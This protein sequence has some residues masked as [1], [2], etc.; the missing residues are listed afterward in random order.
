MKKIVAL[1]LCMLITLCGCGETA[2][3]E[4]SDLDI[5]LPTDNAIDDAVQPPL[6]SGDDSSDS[7]E[8]ETI[9]FVTFG[10]YEQDNNESNGK[11]P[12]EWRV[13][14]GQPAS[15][16]SLFLISEKILDIGVFDSEGDANWSTS[17]IR[18]WLNDTFLNAAFSQEE[19]ERIKIHKHNEHNVFRNIYD[20]TDC[21]PST[22]D[23]VGL[24]DIYDLTRGSYG[25]K[26][27]NEE[28]DT[29]Y[30]AEMT[31]YARNKY[32][33]CDSRKKNCWILTTLSEGN[34]CVGCSEDGVFGGVSQRAYCGIRP[35]IQIS[36]EGIA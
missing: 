14:D 9:E 21:G 29:Y 26:L 20:K 18:V 6:G 10:H 3:N 2:K 32:E 30:F 25:E 4:G 22:E 5:F 1:I 11:E 13:L 17:E 34:S 31:K 7:S 23:K 27:Y 15:G 8:E 16:G 33:R 12:I 36:W 35:V 24:L 19:Q 28:Y